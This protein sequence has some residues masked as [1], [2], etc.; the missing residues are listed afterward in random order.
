MGGAECTIHLRVHVT[1]NDVTECLRRSDRVL[2]LI[3]LT[4]CIVSAVVYGSLAVQRPRTCYQSKAGEV[5]SLIL[6]S[7][8]DESSPFFS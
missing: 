8:R 3:P 1:G 2:Q 5:F 7:F 6:Q 4:L